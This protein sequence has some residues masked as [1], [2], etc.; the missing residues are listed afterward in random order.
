MQ[1]LFQRFLWILL[2]RGQLNLLSRY[3]AQHRFRLRST[4]QARL[5]LLLPFDGV[6]NTSRAQLTHRLAFLVR[7]EI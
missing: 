5:Q 7:F 2:A 4:S 1:I 3:S 6:R